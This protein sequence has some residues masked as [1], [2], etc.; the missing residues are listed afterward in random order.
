MPRSWRATTEYICEASSLK[1]TMTK[2][3]AML[4]GMCQGVDT[5][6]ECVNL[7]MSVSSN[8]MPRFGFIS[9]NSFHTGAFMKMV[10]IKG[11]NEKFS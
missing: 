2:F 3:G 6:S 8:V 7:H 10:F 11:K 4:G 5:M 9:G 1:G